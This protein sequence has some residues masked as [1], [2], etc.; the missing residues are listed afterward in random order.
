MCSHMKNLANNSIHKKCILIEDRDKKR[1]V[2][3]KFAYYNEM[4]EF[5]DENFIAY[6]VI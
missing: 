4:R 1:I 6:I 3:K 5:E 2:R